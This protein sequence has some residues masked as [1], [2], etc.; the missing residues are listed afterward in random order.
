VKGKFCF[1][2][3]DKTEELPLNSK[4]KQ[5]VAILQCIMNQKYQETL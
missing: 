5:R 4:V 1:N 2:L 3:T